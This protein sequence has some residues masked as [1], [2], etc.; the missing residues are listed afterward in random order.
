MTLGETIPA[1]V[2]Q[3][4]ERKCLYSLYQDS[5]IHRNATFYIKKKNKTKPNEREREKGEGE[6][7]QWWDKHSTTLS[8][9]SSPHLFHELSFDSL[10]YQKNGSQNLNRPRSNSECPRNRRDAEV[11]FPSMK[12]ITAL[13]TSECLP[14]LGCFLAM[15]SLLM[16]AER[17]Q[18][19]C[20]K[21]SE[22]GSP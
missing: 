15:P 4:E 20:V 19:C 18:M 2:C 22:S 9:K 21:V 17:L 14:M 11:G 10:I 5:Q 7:T 13:S 3:P 12:N 16:E 8:H 6:D 1:L